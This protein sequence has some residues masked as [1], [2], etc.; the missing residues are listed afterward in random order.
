MSVVLKEKR[1]EEDERDEAIKK[2][3]KLLEERIE[4]LRRLLEII[5]D[6]VKSPNGLTSLK[7]LKRVADEIRELA[8]P[9]KLDEEDNEFLKALLKNS[10][11]KPKEEGIFLKVEE[12]LEIKGK[13]IGGLDPT[14]SE[15]QQV[16]LV[17]KESRQE[18]PKAETEI[19]EVIGKIEEGLEELRKKIEGF[20]PDVEKLQAVRALEQVK[21]TAESLQWAI[22]HDL[23][24]RSF[25]E[26]PREVKNNYAFVA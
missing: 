16:E 25:G 15:L 18:I 23:R 12:T 13:S 20:Y 21:E 19:K 4:E 8:L 24:A 22:F 5:R 11:G 17:V 3:P 7:D 6:A 14:K 26:E 10:E 9:L 1:K 2:S